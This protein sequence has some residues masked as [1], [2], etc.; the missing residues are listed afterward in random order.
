MTDPK[1]DGDWHSGALKIN[2]MSIVHHLSN[3]MVCLLYFHLQ[4]ALLAKQ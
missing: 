1:S 3:V 4:K 2:N